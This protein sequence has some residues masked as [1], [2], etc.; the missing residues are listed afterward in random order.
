MVGTILGAFGSD[1][2]RKLEDPCHFPKQILRI[3][4]IV[5]KAP[6]RYHIFLRADH[7]R[8]SI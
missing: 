8:S 3:F 6:E 1:R 2:A 5:P 7:T 4:T